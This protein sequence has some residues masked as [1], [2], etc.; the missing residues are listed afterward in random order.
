MQKRSRR[1]HGI[2][3]RKISVSVSAE[4]LKILSTRANRLYRGNVSA[5]VHDMVTALKR[6]QAADELLETLGGER[7]TE[8]EIQAVRDEVASAPVRRRKR[9]KA[10]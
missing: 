5:L 8:H 3:S 9:R 1:A 2:K 4:D 10:A 6:E 7:V